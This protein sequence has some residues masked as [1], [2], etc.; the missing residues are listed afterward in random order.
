MK[1]AIDGLKRNLFSVFSCFLVY[2]SCIVLPVVSYLFH[3]S[4]WKTS[5]NKKFN[6]NGIHLGRQEVVKHQA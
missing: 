6:Y 5:L 4:I 3:I 2:F 1:S